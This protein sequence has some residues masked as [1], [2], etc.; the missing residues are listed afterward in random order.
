M[1]PT[2]EASAMVPRIFLK[3]ATAEDRVFLRKWSYGIAAVYGA[4]AL[5][6]VGIGVGLGGSKNTLQANSGAAHNNISSALDR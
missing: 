4:L 3:N 2:S 1:T 6:L 5:A